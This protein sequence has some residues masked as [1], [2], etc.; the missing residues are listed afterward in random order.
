MENQWR[1]VE[2]DMKEERIKKSLGMEVWQIGQ[3]QGLMVFY[4]TLHPLW[5]RNM[6]ESEHKWT[7][8]KLRLFW[9]CS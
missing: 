6:Q 1:E 2:I 9:R 5:L 4:I 3:S 7:W 8:R